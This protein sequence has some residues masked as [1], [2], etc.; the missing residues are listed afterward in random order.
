MADEDG[1]E[2]GEGLE[3]LGFAFVASGEAAVVGE[4]GQARLDDPPVSAE[5]LGG[6]DAFAGDAHGDAAAAD[7]GPDRLV[8]VG[9]VRVQLARAAA[10]PAATAP[11]RGEGIQQREQQ[12]RVR[13]VRG[14]DQHLQRHA[15]PVAQDVDL[16]AWFAAVDRVWPGQVPL[17]SARTLI[18]SIIALDQ[19]IPP[20]T[21]NRC[22]SA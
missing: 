12:L 10:G 11:H 3:V 15:P 4:P 1:G 8:V 5:S 22:S 14:G 13:G 16:R 20:A 21:F 17:F 9:L 7:L 19:S 6:L 2:V 18:E